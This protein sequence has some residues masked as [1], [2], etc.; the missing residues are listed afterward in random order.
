MWYVFVLVVSQLW[1]ETCCF[2]MFINDFFFLGI[3]AEGM[4]TFQDV[5]FTEMKSAFLA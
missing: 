4:K 3:V 2:F 5:T 1:E